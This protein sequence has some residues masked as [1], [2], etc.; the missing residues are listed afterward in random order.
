MLLLSPLAP[1]VAVAAAAAAVSLCGV[2][3]CLS[4][5]GFGCRSAAF[6]S[7]CCCLLSYMALSSPLLLLL[8]LLLVLG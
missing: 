3:R 1:Y 4:V 6:V 7:C 8:L 2:G 5:D